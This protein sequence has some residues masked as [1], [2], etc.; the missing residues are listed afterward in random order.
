MD[1]NMRPKHF[2]VGGWLIIVG[3][4]I[5]IIGI[6]FWKVS[7]GAEKYIPLSTVSEELDAGDL[8]GIDIDVGT[9]KLTVKTHQ[10]DKVMIEATD[11][12]KDE[13][14]YKVE[15]GVFKIYSKRNVHVIGLS[16]MGLPGRSTEMTVTVPEKVYD[17][18]ELDLGAGEADISGI[19]A[20]TADLD[21]GAGNVKLEDFVI[22]KLDID[23]GTGDLKYTGEINESGDIDCGTGNVELKLSASYSDYTL[24]IDKGI[25]SVD[26]N[27]GSAPATGR[28]IKLDIDC[29]IGNVTLS[30]E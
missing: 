23:C 6:I 9:C 15:D 1:E 27:K 7:G 24:D 11:F 19:S 29:G 13:Y 21:L 10:S 25:G 4:V 14:G 17:L 18:F 26:I 20:R 8:T 2:P 5:L 28:D 30:F 22:D 12:P 3:V 16:S